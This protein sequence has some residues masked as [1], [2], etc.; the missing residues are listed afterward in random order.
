MTFTWANGGCDFAD[1][2]S[3]RV[4]TFFLL[5]FVSAGRCP[6]GRLQR[7]YSLLFR[8]KSSTIW[9]WLWGDL[10]TWKQTFFSHGYCLSLALKL[11]SILYQICSPVPQ[12]R[13][14]SERAQSTDAGRTQV[15]LMMRRGKEVTE[16]HRAWKLLELCKCEICTKHLKK[17]A[18]TA[19][20]QL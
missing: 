1:Y 4:S 8:G 9:F 2:F 15:V 7:I 12:H 10:E 11:L 3:L 18:T 14:L 6:C 20:M 16:R 19:G 17:Q 13:R 5:T